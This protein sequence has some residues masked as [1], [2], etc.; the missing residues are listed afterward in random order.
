[1]WI[2]SEFSVAWIVSVLKLKFK[3]LQYFRSRWKQAQGK[4]LSAYPYILFPSVLLAF[5]SELK[6]DPTERQILLTDLPLNPSKNREK[7]VETMF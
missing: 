7:M 6:I 3:L 2:I 1:M 4:T 5:Y